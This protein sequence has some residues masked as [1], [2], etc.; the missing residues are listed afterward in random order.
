[1]EHRQDEAGAL[2]GTEEDGERQDVDVA[3][4]GEAR[5]GDANPGR[6][7]GYQ[8]PFDWRQVGQWQHRAEDCSLLPDS[9]SRLPAVCD[10]R[11]RSTRLRRSSQPQAGGNVSDMDASDLGSDRA[12]PDDVFAS[13][14]EAGNGRAREGLPPGYRMR[15]ETHYVDTLVTRRERFELPARPSAPLEPEGDDGEHRPLSSPRARRRSDR[16]LA[17]LGDEIAAIFSAAALLDSGAAPVAR[18][19]GQELIRAQAWRA[20]W[21]LKAS[22][23]L[24]GRH[25]VD[26]RPTRLTALVEQLHAGLIPECRLS[27]ITLGVHA[28]DVTVLGDAPLISTGVT[29][30]VLA[31]AGLLTGCQ[32]AAIRVTFDVVAGQLRAV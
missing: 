19:T 32:G 2:A 16:V 7:D 14:H 10:C 29:G 27:G 15:A 31:T 21:L 1:N 20:A 26:P 3:D 4:T 11:A 24:D 25:T 18:Q 6:G 23:I 5:L 28:P 17:Q 8:D 22:L 9:R 30:A 13:E 12:L